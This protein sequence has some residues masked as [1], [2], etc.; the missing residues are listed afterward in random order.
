[1]E[2][3]AIKPPANFGR[4]KKTLFAI[5]VNAYQNPRSVKRALYD[6]GAGAAGLTLA[7]FNPYYDWGGVRRE[8]QIALGQEDGRIGLNSSAQTLTRD[9]IE[10]GFHEKF[11]SG[12]FEQKRFY[13]AWYNLQHYLSHPAVTVRRVLLGT[14][15]ATLAI[16]AK[17][18]FDSF[19]DH[20]PK[21]GIAIMVMGLII[22]RIFFQAVSMG[23]KTLEPLIDYLGKLDV[24]ILSEQVRFRTLTFLKKHCLLR[25]SRNQGVD[26]RHL[27]VL[28]NIIVKDD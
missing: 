1:M 12:P 22:S 10:R 25:E 17:T 13:S 16:S 9:Q 7:P 5:G 21:R 24:K 19:R 23:Q 4:V 18:V 2:A 15:A 6:I 26:D 3:A 20:M 28:K 14:S 8:V 11:V 27:S